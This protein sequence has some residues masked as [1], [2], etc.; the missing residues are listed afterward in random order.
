MCFFCIPITATEI[1]ACI[2]CNFTPCDYFNP[3]FCQCRPGLNS[4]KTAHSFHIKWVKCAKDFRKIQG[5]QISQ[6]V[7]LKDVL[8]KGEKPKFGQHIFYL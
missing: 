4:L 7:Q 6:V 3:N 2:W 8:L 5:Q 1:G